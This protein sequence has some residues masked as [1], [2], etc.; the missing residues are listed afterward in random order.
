MS[1]FVCPVC[2][3]DLKK[4]GGSL[5]CENNHSFDIAKSGY[6][7]LLLSQQIK[8]KHHGD[9]KRMVRARRD[10]LNQGYYRPLLEGLLEAVKK[11][12][13]Q[14]STIFDAGCGECWYTAN[15]CEYL[16]KNQIEFE[17]LAA[18]ISKDALSTGAKRGREIKLAV[19]SVFRLPLKD[20]SCD[21]LISVFAPFCREEFFRVLKKGGVLIR[22]VPLERHLLSLK[23]AV[24]DNA[25]LNHLEDSALDGFKLM[26]KLEIK[27]A[28]RLRSNKDIT[29]VFTM[30]PYYYKTSAEDQKKLQSLT[31]LETETEF[32]ILI[33][34]RER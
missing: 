6:V 27:N 31:E 10:F 21:I 26:E 7:N 30:T 5:R 8:A 18:D 16:T 14:G 23:T 4:N 22:A 29:N 19:A 34:R 25:Y 1:C 33:Y 12:V 9:D 24:Y 32:G 13:K 28:I 3:M 15:L 20:E 17:M 11:Y 2:G